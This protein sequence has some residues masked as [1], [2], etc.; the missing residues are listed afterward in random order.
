MKKTSKILAALLALCMMVAFAA[1]DAAPAASDSTPASAPESQPAESTPAEGGASTDASALVAEAAT[2]MEA[3]DG[4]S[5]DMTMDMDMTVMGQQVTTTMD[6]TISMVQEPLQLS[7]VMDVETAGQAMQMEM[8]AVQDGDTV[9]MYTKM[10]DEWTETTATVEDVK[11]QANADAAANY[12]NG[13]QDVTIEGDETIGG[14]ECVKV[15]G[16]V[17]GDD[18]Q[19]A[20]AQGGGLDTFAQSGVDLSAI[21]DSMSVPV[22]VWISKDGGDMMRMEMDMTQTMNDMLDI[23]FA[24]VDTSELEGVTL[25]YSVDGFTMT[26]EYTAFEGVSVPVPEGIAA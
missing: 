18:A 12:L 20:M 25:D 16:V 15:S 11:S 4:V 5:Y 17:T 22:T 7:M 8:Y 3:A 24:S 1:C 14:V 6:G 21:L 23:I 10:G 13:L 2:N 9:T 26:M 19:E